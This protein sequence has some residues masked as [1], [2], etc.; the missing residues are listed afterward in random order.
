MLELVV[1]FAL[2]SQEP[3]RTLLMSEVE[4]AERLVLAPKVL[5]VETSDRI[6]GGWVR[7]WWVARIADT[8]AASRATK[9]SP[10]SLTRLVIRDIQ[11]SDETGAGW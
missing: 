3:D 4:K 11:A 2:A 10:F 8:S 7:R 5:Q 6:T 9:P 1:A